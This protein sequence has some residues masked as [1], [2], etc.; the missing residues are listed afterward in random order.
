MYVPPSSLYAPVPPEYANHTLKQ[1]FKIRNDLIKQVRYLKFVHF[2][3]PYS[4]RIS[5]D[6]LVQKEIELARIKIDPVYTAIWHHLK[7]R[8]HSSVR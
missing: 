4:R 2:N 6:P 8:Q 3:D 5:K 7:Q 1:L